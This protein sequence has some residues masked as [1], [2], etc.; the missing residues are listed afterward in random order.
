[1]HQ[2]FSSKVK[3]IRM[4]TWYNF[5][6]FN[7]TVLYTFVCEVPVL[8]A[9]PSFSLNTFLAMEAQ[10]RLVLTSVGVSGLGFSSIFLVRKDPMED[11]V[12]SWGCWNKIGSFILSGSRSTKDNCLV[13][14]GIKNELWSRNRFFFRVYVVDKKVKCN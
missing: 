8:K 9:K 2:C 1:M 6:E 3:M 7:S 11:D 10:S 14:K 5:Y 12:L 13:Y 4:Y